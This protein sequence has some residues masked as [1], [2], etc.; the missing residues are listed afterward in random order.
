MRSAV[1]SQS[2][3]FKQL[4]MCSKGFISTGAER[5]QEFQKDNLKLS[6]GHWISILDSKEV[7]HMN[8]RNSPA[9]QSLIFH[10]GTM[11]KVFKRTANSA[12]LHLKLDPCDS[13]GKLPSHSRNSLLQASSVPGTGQRTALQKGR[14]IQLLIHQ[15]PVH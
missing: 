1:T 13:Q 15:I 9:A 8:S 5:Q 4:P 10:L 2:K 12:I 7:L 6:T 3:T 14:F 11:G